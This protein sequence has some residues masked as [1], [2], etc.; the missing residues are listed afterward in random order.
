M[1][2]ETVR[3]LLVDRVQELPE[4]D[5]AVAPVGLADDLACC[6]IQSREQ[7]GRSVAQVLGGLALPLG[8][9]GLTPLQ[10][11]N[12]GPF[13][14]AKDERIVRWVHVE[15]CD[16]ADLLDE[17]VVGESVISVKVPCLWGCSL[18]AR[19]T[20]LTEAWLTPTRSVR[21]PPDRDHQDR[22]IVIA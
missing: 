21:V 8:Q 1:D 18:K 20:R 17:E 9:H 6:D 3:S 11:L 5:R 10:G 13:V 19:H 12:L 2:L 14:H 4:L 15:A 16:I 22:C 7:R